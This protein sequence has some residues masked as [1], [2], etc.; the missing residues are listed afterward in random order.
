MVPHPN[1]WGG[2]AS[3]LFVVSTLPMLYRAV[4]TRTLADYSGYSLVLS[5]LGNM[6]YWFYV[7]SLPFGPLW[8]LHG[9]YTVITLLM[10][11]F[12][13]RWGRCDR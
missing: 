9:Y 5:S 11:I 3:L 1:L 7:V 6:V 2:L 8:V 4:Q 10:L 12:W 13:W